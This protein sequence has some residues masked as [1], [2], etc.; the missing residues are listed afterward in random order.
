MAND[1]AGNVLATRFVKILGES[2][3]G[4]GVSLL[5]DGK[6]V[7]GGAHLAAG[8]AARMLIGPPGWILVA[9]NSYSQSVSEKHL[10]EHLMPAP[11]VAAEKSRSTAGK[12]R[13]TKE[14]KAKA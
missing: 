10:Y 3:L 4:P 7:K 13:S 14:T 2:F 12:S 8:I 1:L 11:R 9:A 6:I 5:L